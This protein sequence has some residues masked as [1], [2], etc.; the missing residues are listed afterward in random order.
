VEREGRREEGTNRRK[1]DKSGPRVEKLEKQRCD[2]LFKAMAIYREKIGHGEGG[3]NVP[4]VGKEVEA[5]LDNAKKTREKKKKK[6][7]KKNPNE[8]RRN[9]CYQR[10]ITKKC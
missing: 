4:M 2:P 10:K 3:G 8:R 1:W 7:E 5:V 6:K 9:S